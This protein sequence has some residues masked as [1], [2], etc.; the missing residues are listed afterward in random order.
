VVKEVKE[1]E[2]A[3]LWDKEITYKRYLIDR[4]FDC[5]VVTPGTLAAPFFSTRLCRLLIVPAGFGNTLYSRI[6]K[7]LRATR[8]VITDFVKGG[9][10][11]LVSGSF[12][13]GGA[14]DW[15][16]IKIEYVMEERRVKIE[17][18]TEHEA[19]TMVEK[20][21]CFCDGYFEEVDAGCE[22]L[23]TVKRDED[24]KAIL[25]VS[26]YGAG[27]IIATTIHEYPSEQFLAY[28]VGHERES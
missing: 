11:L 19:A 4:G 25:V 12:S 14:Y 7:E 1:I 23:L 21:E 10:T 26:R 9:G 13:I 8:M 17:L 3:L 15:L 5:E 20:D 27:K 2:I 24:E 18:I 28:C 22:G 6:L 16:P